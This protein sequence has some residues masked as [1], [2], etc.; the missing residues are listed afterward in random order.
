MQGQPASAGDCAKCTRL[1]VPLFPGLWA[2]I[3]DTS[4]SQGCK[5]RGDSLC[6]ALRTGADAI[7]AG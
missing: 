4:T 5:G 3:K 1:S 7:S 6:K 2:G